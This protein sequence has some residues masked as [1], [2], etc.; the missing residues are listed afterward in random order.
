MRRILHW[1]LLIFLIIPPL[2]S[3]IGMLLGL[4]Y[5]LEAFRVW[6]F[7]DPFRYGL[8]VLDIAAA[9]LIALPATTRIGVVL[10]A[11]VIGLTLLMNLT[12]GTA[13]K[14]IPEA[15]VILLYGVLFYLQHPARK[16]KAPVRRPVI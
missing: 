10:A 6:G 11:S 16:E 1:T 15:G 7:S 9:I 3:G 13:A 8:G 2:G 5:I 4:D 12:H 14:A